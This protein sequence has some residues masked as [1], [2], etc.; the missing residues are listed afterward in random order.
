MS[1]VDIKAAKTLAKPNTAS[2]KAPNPKRPNS[3]VCNTTAEEIS[4]MG[5]QIDTMTED[6]KEIRGSLKDIMRREEMEKFIHQTVTK[7]I[8][9]LNENMEVT[10]SIKVDEKTKPLQDK[11]NTLESENKSLRDDMKTLKTTIT[12]QGSKLAECEARSK[13]ALSKS[14]YNEQYSRKNNVKIMDLA[15][16]PSE[17]END[18]ITEV[19]KLLKKK[20]V[21]LDPSKILAIHRIPGK[22]GHA[23]PVL[24]KFTNNTEKKK[25]MIHRTAF[26]T[27]GHRIADDVTKLNAGLIKS[28]SDHPTITQAWYF[29]GYVYGRASTDRRYRFDLFDIVED[30]LKK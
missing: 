13:D 28:L 19:S 16:K 15:E 3:D 6:M 20:E 26:K 17:S 9:E 1:K 27:M 2:G 11:I 10:I 14:N 23:K 8:T 7:I 30:V 18:L 21:T 4:F 25:V 5:T 29:N 12:K 22:E 24:I